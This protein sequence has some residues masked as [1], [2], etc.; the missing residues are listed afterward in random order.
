M[1]Q[2]KRAIKTTE[3]IRKKARIGFGRINLDGW[4][5]ERNDATA[6]VVANVSRAAIQKYKGRFTSGSI[7]LGI[8]W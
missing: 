7:R 5:D 4:L 6:R 8:P 3:K 2:V 1:N